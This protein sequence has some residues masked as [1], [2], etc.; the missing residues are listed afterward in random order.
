MPPPSRAPDA[1]Q[2]KK[3]AKTSEYWGI[4]SLSGDAWTLIG[5]PYAREL[6]PMHRVSAAPGK[7]TVKCFSSV[8]SKSEPAEAAVLEGRGY[9]HD[10]PGGRRQLR[11]PRPSFRQADQGR[12]SRAV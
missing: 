6:C 4:S 11:N 3:L 1:K 7:Q 2:A 8:F 10:V 9:G 12:C 5:P